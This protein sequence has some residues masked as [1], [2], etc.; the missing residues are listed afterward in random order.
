MPNEKQVLSVERAT[1]L[2]GA[3]VVTVDC[4]RSIEREVIAAVTL[5]AITDEQILNEFEQRTMSLTNSDGTPTINGVRV[6][7][8]VRSLL[9]CSGTC[10]AT[11]P[12]TLTA[13]DVE[14]QYIDD[15]HIGSGLPRAT[16]P[17]GFC[18]KHRHGFNR[19]DLASL[20]R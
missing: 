11:A 15:V 4:V 13:E 19:D 5:A 14:R 20:A 1:Q 6:I 18:A 17:C 16:C 7:E 12:M 3:L 9:A 2:A 8:G 10:A